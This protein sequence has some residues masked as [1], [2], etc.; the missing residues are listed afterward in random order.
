MA[1]KWRGFRFLI[2]GICG[3]LLFPQTLLAQPPLKGVSTVSLPYLERLSDQA[4]R[5]LS[6]Q[7]TEKL[8]PQGQVAGRIKLWD[9]W[10]KPQQPGSLVTAGKNQV[11]M[12]PP[13][14]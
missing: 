2:G 12:F 7:G 4:L 1:K 14:H 13:Q 10:A 3:L 9:D 6:G 5:Q 8:F 11:V